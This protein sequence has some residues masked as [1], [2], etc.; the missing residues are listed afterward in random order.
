MNELRHY[1]AVGG[2]VMYPL[3]AANILLWFAVGYR[4]SALRR[5]SA[6]PVRTLVDRALAG[7][8]DPGRGIIDSA[9]ARGVEAFRRGRPHLRRTLDD[10]FGDYNRDLKKFSVLVG[11]IVVVSPLLGLLGTVTGMVETF[12][13]M[14]DRALFSQSGGI[15][16]GISQALTATQ[17][18]LAVAVPGLVLKGYLDRK[19]RAIE[20]DLLQIKDIL[21]TLPLG[22]HGATVL[23]RGAKGPEIEIIEAVRTAECESC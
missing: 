1:M 21:C 15:A 13:S 16:G 12:A 20:T 10:L 23:S 9:V 2:Y 11:L 7:R 4:V 17:L 3:M 14:T 18:G 19:Q 6:D 5:G 22:H 8:T